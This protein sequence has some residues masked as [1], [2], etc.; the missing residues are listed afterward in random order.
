M[1]SMNVVATQSP[2]NIPVTRG[3][4]DL[5]TSQMQYSKLTHSAIRLHKLCIF[6]E[7][8]FANLG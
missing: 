2:S 1:K 6:E 7:D 4:F 3:E 8:E 5:K